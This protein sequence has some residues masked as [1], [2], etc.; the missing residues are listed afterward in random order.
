MHLHF[1]RALLT[2]TLGSYF[3]LTELPL[4]R[5]IL[6]LVTILSI[7]ADLIVNLIILQ[8]LQKLIFT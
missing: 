4:L 1:K 7:S 8:I 6:N 5:F 3:S 2:D